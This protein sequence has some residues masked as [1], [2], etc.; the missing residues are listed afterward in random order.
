MAGSTGTNVYDQSAGALQQAG[1]G[2]LQAGNMYATGTGDTGQNAINSLN[3]AGGM[4]SDPNYGF[5]SAGG[6]NPADYQA[7]MQANA[8]AIHSQMSKYY[9]PYTSEVINNASSDINRMLKTQLGNVGASADAAGAFG[10]ARHGLVEAETNRAAMDTLA[11][12]SAGLRSNMF[13]TAAGLA[14]QDISNI[15]G[16][17]LANQSA[18][19][20]AR[21]YGATAANQAG[22]Y[23]SDLAARLSMFNAGNDMSRVGDLMN[24]AGGY[25]AQQGLNLQDL[26]SRAGG[27]NSTAGTLAGLGQTGYGLANNVTNQQMQYG[28]MGQ[29]LNQQLM[30]SARSMFE[31]YIGQPSNLLNLRLASV[32]ASPGGNTGTQTSTTQNQTG[33]AALFGSLLSSLSSMLQFKPIP[34]PSDIRLKEKVEVI[35]Y[36]FY[37]TPIYRFHYRGDPYPQIGFM[38]QDLEHTQPDTVTELNGFKAVDYSKVR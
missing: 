15:L 16:V 29:M 33:S 23:N 5:A 32:G 22:Q 13:N 8:P 11:N 3:L 12:T 7:F 21:E 2:A 28:T 4:L 37:G 6:Y 24:L 19:N 36:T 27:L 35:G 26:L 14:G 17:Q 10:G 38:A 30:D 20:R 31:Q 18:T 34:F 1:A 25:Q 9:N